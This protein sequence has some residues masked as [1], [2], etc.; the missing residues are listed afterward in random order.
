MAAIRK[1]DR[2]TIW[3]DT[4]Q[5]QMLSAK[6]IVDDAGSNALLW[7]NTDG[8]VTTIKK[9]ERPTYNPL[10]DMPGIQA[11]RMCSECGDPDD[12]HFHKDAEP[13]PF[14]NGTPPWATAKPSALDEFLEWW[15]HA[16]RFSPSISVGEMKRR[17]D[18]LREG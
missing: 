2:L 5:G 13:D 15:D 1:G 14:A 10:S 12:G 3:V 6:V 7:V 11:P 18:K 16:Q 17:I 4:G 8:S 9:V